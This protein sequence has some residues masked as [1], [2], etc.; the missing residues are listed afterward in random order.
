V[1][2][3]NHIITRQ[4]VDGIQRN[5]AAMEDAQRRVLSGLRIERPSDD[6]AGAVGVMSADRQLSGLAQYR[7]NIQAA[8]ARLN[9]EETV[10][11]GVSAL[12]ERARELAI[13]QAGAT[14]NAQTRAIAK[15]EVDQLLAQAIALGNTPYNGGYLFGGQFADAAPFDAAGATSATRPPTGA[16]L[17]EIDAGRQLTVHHD[18]VQVFVDTDALQA[19]QDLSAALGASSDTQ[20]GAALT[21]LDGAH[22]N[23]QKVLGETGANALQL[24]VAASNIAS[25]AGTLETF[26]ADLSEVEMEEAI[27]RLVSRQTAF[28]AAL[29]ATSRMISLT[30]TDY[31]R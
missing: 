30:L 5:L 27:S 14:G 18:A 12:L 6:P 17:V 21:R 4:S 22:T 25:V 15:I 28:Q 29:A 20:I 9:A 8:E 10:L 13:G 24:E 2:I 1:R 31:L 3:T 7:R 26:R 23:V 19:L 16:A 11:D